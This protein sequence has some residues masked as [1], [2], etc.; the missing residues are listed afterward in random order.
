MPTLEAIC[1]SSTIDATRPTTYVDDRK[2]GYRFMCAEAAWILSGDDR[3][4]TIKPYSKEI[5]RFSDNGVTFFG[6]YGPKLVEQ[7]D[8]CLDKLASSP[9][10]R[11]A[12]I[13]I[14]REQPPGTKDVPC[15]LSWQFLIRR[16]LLH[17]VAT[18]RSSDA[19]LGW[20][21][22]VFTQAMIIHAM[23]LDLRQ[24]G[25]NVSPGCVTLTAGSQH[26][27]EKNLF[28]A[29]ACLRSAVEPSGLSLDIGYLSTKEQLI[30]QLWLVARTDTCAHDLQNNFLI[31]LK[32]LLDHK[33]RLDHDQR[34]KAIEGENHGH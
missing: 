22:D 32:F 28:G 11:Q 17:L 27:Y 8:Y 10:T 20:P 16:N 18:M 14:W 26:L 25:I 15:T 6:A 13:N 29:L 12:V 23:C 21:Y 7:W 2:L 3:V 4:E 24:K 31:N 30:E 9:D 19:W 33:Q 1:Y 34:M 5:E